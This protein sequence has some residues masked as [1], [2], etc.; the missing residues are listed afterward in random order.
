MNIGIV[1]EEQTTAVESSVTWE[2]PLAEDREAL[3]TSTA[4]LARRLKAP[5]N[6]VTRS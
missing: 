6:R 5:T 1:I 4:E 2:N 3:D